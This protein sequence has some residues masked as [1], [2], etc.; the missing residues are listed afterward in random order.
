MRY[1]YVP[2]LLLAVVSLASAAGAAPVWEFGAC[3]DEKQGEWTPGGGGDICGGET[4]TLRQGDHVELVW[5]E[6]PETEGNVFHSQL[7]SALLSPGTVSGNVGSVET[8]VEYWNG[9]TYL[10]HDTVA[11]EEGGRWI[12]TGDVLNDIGGNTEQY[13]L[14]IN[15]THQQDAPIAE[16]AVDDAEMR[17]NYTRLGTFSYATSE[18]DGSPVLNASG[19]E[20]GEAVRV[21]SNTTCSNGYCGETQSFLTVNGSRL[22][23]GTVEGIS[24]LDEGQPEAGELC[25]GTPDHGVCG[26]ARMATEWTVEGE[27]TGAYDVAVETVSDYPSEEET[28]VMSTASG[29]AV[30]SVAPSVFLNDISPDGASSA[31]DAEIQ[32]SSTVDANLTCEVAGTHCSE[33]V[34]PGQGAAASCSLGNPDYGLE[35]QLTCGLENVEHDVSAEM[36]TG[37]D[38]SGVVSGVSVGQEDVAQGDNVTVF[39]S[40]KNTG[41]IALSSGANSNGNTAITALLEGPGGDDV[42]KNV[43]SDDLAVSP[44]DTATVPVE[45]PVPGDAPTGGWNASCQDYRLI[46]SHSLDA[47][48][49]EAGFTVSP[50]AAQLTIDVVSPQPDTI[51]HVGQEIEVD[52][53]IETPDGANVSG[54]DVNVN[55][56]VMEESGAGNYKTD[57]VIPQTEDIYMLNIVAEKGEM[58][59][60]TSLALNVERG[61][62]MKEIPVRERYKVGETVSVNISLDAERAWNGGVAQAVFRSPD[63][64][65]VEIIEKTVDDTSFSLSHTIQNVEMTGV[66][67]VE[68]NVQDE[69]EAVQ[70]SR[71]FE[72]AP[73]NPG[74]FYLEFLSPTSQ[75]FSPGENVTVEVRTVDAFSGNGIPVE[76]VSCEIGNVSQELSESGRMYSGKMMVPHTIS[77]DSMNLVCSAVRN[78]ETSTISRDRTMELDVERLPLHVDVVRPSDGRLSGGEKQTLRVNIT[79]EGE[80]AQGLD[81]ELLI[82]G[83]NASVPLS[84][85]R[86]GTYQ[87]HFHIPRDA[88]SIRL[89]TVNQ[90]QDI[91]WDARPTIAVVERP[92]LIPLLVIFI[93][94]VLGVIL[95]GVYIRRWNKNSRIFPSSEGGRRRHLQKRRNDLVRKRDSVKESIREAQKRY[96]ERDISRESFA[97]IMERYEKEKTEI[98]NE[99]EE[100]EKEMENLDAERGSDGS[101]ESGTE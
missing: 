40:I 92:I 76:S 17:V 68:V 91:V 42:A 64:S 38:V 44:G 37:F 74:D 15:N 48:G 10:L 85:L 27:A 7:L 26:N 47:G 11:L 43:T 101:G 80:P 97:R 9:S 16:L 87:T 21:A 1:L 69:Y 23:Q 84:E 49:V 98:E 56:Q 63:G 73:P 13:R 52:L 19:V 22:G 29:I 89:R 65:A 90:S 50:N 55:G 94:S 4:V 77:K 96:F 3:H 6:T 41:D 60:S 71:S 57:I 39:C 72:V 100:V 58:Q 62:S 93:S 25:A 59:G 18:G 75:E 54:A 53:D 24:L 83:K 51:F 5:A 79:R 32:Y 95:Y 12:S 36:D 66:W 46:G 33:T 78:Y 31:L 34:V 45:L 88:A 30:G 8:T 67:R 35:N 61:I 20:K 28:G 2:V 81:M 99:I 14:R 82:G 70:A 86:P